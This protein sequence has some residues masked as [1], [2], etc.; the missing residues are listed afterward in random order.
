MLVAVPAP[1]V[2]QAEAAERMV[3]LATERNVYKKLYEDLLA[4]VLGE[5]ADEE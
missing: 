5:E 1:A 2:R 4:K 3:R